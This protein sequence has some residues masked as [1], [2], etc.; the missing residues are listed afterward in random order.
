MNFDFPTEDYGVIAHDVVDQVRIESDEAEQAAYDGVNELYDLDAEL[1]VDPIEAS[2]R[3][4]LTLEESTEVMAG[5]ANWKRMKDAEKAMAEGN[6]VVTETALLTEKARLNVSK[7][8]VLTQAIAN[9]DR[10]LLLE[11]ERGKLIEQKAIGLALQGVTQQLLNEREVT[12][13]QLEME[14]TEA[15][16]Q[17]TVADIEAIRSSTETKM[18]RAR[19]ADLKAAGIEGTYDAN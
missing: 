3:P 18:L 5:L 13:I 8:N 11:T 19:D 12:V 14:K 15:I 6:V 16:I 9:E 2:Q 7:R 1:A 10:K 17:G 4:G